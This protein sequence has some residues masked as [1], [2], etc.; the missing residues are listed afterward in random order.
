MGTPIKI[1][2][3]W[4]CY[5]WRDHGHYWQLGD[6]TLS[7]SRDPG[8]LPGWFV[9]SVDLDLDLQLTDSDDIVEYDLLDE[10]ERVLKIS[11]QDKVDEHRKFEKRW[12]SFLADE[13]TDASLDPE[14]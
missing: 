13:D 11:Y 4:K 6:A 14:P 9:H 3:K 2:K 8:L 7:R 12:N 1:Y 10:A 5:N